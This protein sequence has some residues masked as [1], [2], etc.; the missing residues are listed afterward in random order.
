MGWKKRLFSNI[1]W[2]NVL[3]SFGE[4]SGYSK[5]PGGFVPYFQYRIGDYNSDLHYDAPLKKGR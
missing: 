3:A 1:F 5:E 2:R 4:R